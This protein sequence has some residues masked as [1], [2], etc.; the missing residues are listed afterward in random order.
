MRLP[1]AMPVNTLLS[2][3]GDTLAGIDRNLERMDMHP[4][5]ANRRFGGRRWNV[6]WPASI[7]IE[8]RTF[9]CTILDLSLTGARIEGYGLRPASSV[10]TLECEKFGTLAAR[11]KWVRD[12]RAGLHFELRAAEVQAILQPVV[13]GMGRRESAPAARPQRAS[14]G[15]RRTAQ[16]A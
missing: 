5:R 15:R 9:P 4:T 3:T 11:V 10:T 16:A 8:G 7:V 1:G 6:V 14:F 13:P 12:G 2:A